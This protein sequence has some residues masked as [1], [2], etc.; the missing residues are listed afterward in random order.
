VASITFSAFKTAVSAALRDPNNTTFDTAAVGT[1]IQAAL[2][3]V[4]RIAPE[5]FQEDIVPVADTLTYQLR[6]VGVTKALTTPFGVASTNV[7]TSTAHGLVA[8]NAV[9]FRFLTGG[10]GL[11]VGTT[12][13]VIAAGLTANAFEVSA[14]LGGSAVDFT[15]DITAGMFRQV[16]IVPSEPVPEIEVSRVELWKTT[17]TPN[18][19]WWVI[20]PASAGYV[21]DSQTGWSVWNGT[22]FLPNSVHTQF[23]GAETDFLLRV[24][25][26]SPYVQVSA[27]AD[28][29]FVSD[30]VRLAMIAYCQAE[31]ITRLLAERD[32]FAQ[33]QAKANNSDVSP[34]ALMGMLNL[35]R[36]DWRRRSR[37]L[38]RL[39]ARV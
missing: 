25:G 33:W 1:L 7:L 23:D 2:A 29:V 20:P 18:I 17:E 32:L 12:Y 11:V 16:G 22:L 30:E 21:A 3:E 31:A 38:L 28:V 10:S 9:M 27:D 15:T 8:G 35:A 34:A 24:W 5:Q 4:G 14:T 19:R 26:Y 36:D 39:R 37:A 6:Q 13:Y